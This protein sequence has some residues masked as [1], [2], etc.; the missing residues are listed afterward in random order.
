V[1]GANFMDNFSKTNLTNGLRR[2][3]YKE[4]SNND[5]SNLT[6]KDQFNMPNMNESLRFDIARLEA[7]LDII[8]NHIIG[9]SGGGGKANSNLLQAGELNAAE[10]SLLR[11]MTTKQHVVLQLI[12]GGLRNQDIAPI[13]GIGENTVKLHVRAVCKKFGVKT[14]GQAAMFGQEILSKADPEEYQRLSG[15]LPL[16]WSE[17]LRVPDEYA[18]LYAAQENKLQYMRGAE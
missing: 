14:R 15:G 16:D 5:R 10:L 4:L 11:N 18:P 9:Q 13:M 6:I 2:R 3:K 17:D 7:K 12:I 1:E 8:L